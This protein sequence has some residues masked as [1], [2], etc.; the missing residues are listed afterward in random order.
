MTAAEKIRQRYPEDVTPAD[1]GDVAFDYGLAGPDGAWFML[2]KEPKHTKEDIQ[3]AGAYLRR[4]RDV[5]KLN[6][7][8]DE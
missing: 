4:N 3:K 6:W 7:K 8:D 5:V 1:A 2:L